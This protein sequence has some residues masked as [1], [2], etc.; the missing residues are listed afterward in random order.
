[1]KILEKVEEKDTLRILVDS[2]EESLFFLL[3]AY[4]EAD[5]D[6]DIVGV[7]KEHYLIDKTE[8]F[9]KVKKGNPEAVFKK[10]LIKAK[11]DLLSK[12]VK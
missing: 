10:S 12:K 9:V 1:M 6:V 5:S 3:K 2:N 4:L 11:K 7:Y 8:I